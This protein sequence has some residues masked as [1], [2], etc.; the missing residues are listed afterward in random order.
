M[1]TTEPQTTTEAYRQLATTVRDRLADRHTQTLSAQR[2]A[3]ARVLHY[4]STEHL[5][6]RQLEQNL[7]ALGE[8]VGPT[9]RDHLEALRE[10]EVEAPLG[11]GGLARLTACVLE[12]AATLDLPVVGH[13]LRYDFGT[14]Q[15][16]VPAAGG[17]RREWSLT[18]N[19]WELEAPQDRVTVAFG[20]RTEDAGD[21]TGL[22]R[23]WVPDELVDAIPSTMFVPGSATTT[24]NAV[25]F[26]RAATHPG[27]LDQERLAAGEYAEAVR[28]ATQAENI[29]RVYYPDE[30]SDH[31][32]ELRLK[33]Q[34]FLVSG[35][36][37]EIV[38]RYR[39]DFT[40]WTAFPG[41]VAVQLNETHTTLAAVELMRLLV[42]EH[43]VG[44]D[45]AW[46]ITTKVFGF[47]VHT[48]LPEALQTWP[49]WLMHRLLP[50]H[51]EIIYSINYFFLQ[52]VAVRFPGDIGKLGA[53]SL[54]Q[55]GAEPQVRMA[56]LALVSATAVNGVAEQHTRLLT[57]GAFRSFATMWPQKFRTVTNGV[58]PRRFLRLANPG[59]SALVDERLGGSDWVQDAD[60]LAALAPMAGDADLQEAWRAVRRAN[61]V[62]LQE[63]MLAEVG[64]SLNPDALCDVM[65]KR[66]HEYKRQLLKALH[67]VTLYNRI[68]SEPS[69]D[70]APR[71]V[72]FAGRAAPGY[73]PGRQA[74]RLVSAI[75]A[76]INADAACEDR[77]RVVYLPDYS[78]TRGELLAPAADLSEQIA[79]AGMEASGTGNMKLAMNGAHTVATRDGANIDLRRRIG[80]DG[81]H[82]FGLDA[83]RANLLRTN[84]AYQPHTFYESDP[85]LREAMDAISSGVF[86]GGDDDLF[87]PLVDRILGWDPFLTM[88]DYRAY[89]DAQD[90]IEQAWRDVDSWTRTSIL[91]T[92]RS[93]YFSS[94]RTVREYNNQIWRLRPVSPQHEG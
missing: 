23:R 74:M 57:N 87:S 27:A 82:M 13:G 94:D 29:T 72:V 41:A 14:F 55:E 12:S 86:S 93:G 83:A 44:W 61:K 4:L 32:R 33:Q 30:S 81:V 17:E 7:L 18:A 28:E 25:R 22:R 49:I 20:G 1:T 79:L 62:R 77:L 16:G 50:R 9:G 26:W 47:T 8:E 59:L 60:R 24:V 84:G 43:R 91:A 39:E 36:L 76:T 38:A 89:V 53:L 69:R 73:Y 66:F 3:G 63:R 68:R 54:I 58:S 21:P 80:V 78:V 35:A 34:Y 75:A 71:T 45:R 15:Q 85:E 56:H 11:N 2:A 90:R 46:A 67:V 37:Q 10:V 92:A 42:D 64:V 65:M 48:L 70:L 88:A 52:D 31:G 5:P 6:G 40:S 19:P 51:M